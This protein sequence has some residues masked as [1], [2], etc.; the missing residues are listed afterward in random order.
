MSLE[1]GKQSDGQSN[2]DIYAMAEQMLQTL[3]VAW[4]EVAV[5]DVGAGVGHFTRY[6]SQRC[7]H[8]CA[9][10]AYAPGEM[11]PNAEYRAA[12][13]NEPWPVPD[14]WA[15]VAVALEVVEHL[16]NPRHF[17]REMKR[18][19][20]PGGFGFVSTPNNLSLFS[21]LFFLLKGQHRAFQ[22]FSYPAHITPVLPTDMRRILA[23]NDLLLLRFFY[24]NAD[25]LPLWHARV[26]IGGPLFSAN[27]GVLF[28]KPVAACE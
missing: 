23:E 1:L 25:T 10:D 21:R 14:A 6:L 24:T 3:P 22:D 7:R 15:D 5:L 19:L 13:L 17:F 4:E 26:R 12:D 9:L 18:V 20:K 8:V 2:R 11:P 16:E 28:Q 27:F